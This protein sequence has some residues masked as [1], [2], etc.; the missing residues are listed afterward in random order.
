MSAGIYV[1]VPFCLTRCGYC[2][3][4]AYAGLEMG[5]T[6]YDAAVAGLGGCPFAA[7][8][9][10]AGNI[11]TEDF[12]F[13]C[14]EMGVETGLDIERVRFAGLFATEDQSIGMSAFMAKEK[15]SFTGR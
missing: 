2:D 4:N 3:F 1:H 7:T 8:D 5:V 12:A 11:C 14:E 9:G 6:R 10:A 13:M 15:P